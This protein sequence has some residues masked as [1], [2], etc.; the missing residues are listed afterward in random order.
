MAA[1][2]GAGT[3]LAVD[4]NPAA[5]RTATKNTELHRFAGVIEV[6]ESDLFSTVAPGETFEVITMKP[7]YTLHLASDYVEA[8]TWDRHFALH[9]RLPMFSGFSPQAAVS[10]WGRLASDQ[11]TGSDH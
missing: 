1:Y 9:Q 6:R 5:V 4:E 8:S 2:A 11:S 3:F 7:P 10:T